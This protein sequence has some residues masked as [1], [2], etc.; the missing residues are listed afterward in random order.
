[1]VATFLKAQQGWQLLLEPSTP[2][3]L[4]AEN[5]RGAPYRVRR[6][7]LQILCWSSFL[8]HWIT[9]DDH[10]D[11]KNRWG[12]DIRRTNGA[13]SCSVENRLQNLICDN[14]CHKTLSSAE[15]NIKQLTH[16]RVPLGVR[17]N[18]EGCLQYLPKLFCA[19][20]L[21]IGIREA[22]KHS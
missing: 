9:V 2:P 7:A 18:I 1:M 6:E 20:L 4:F 12:F 10:F 14:N 3:R 22:C 13:S 19:Y 8:Y 11:A 21:M 17:R 15:E 16:A 5:S